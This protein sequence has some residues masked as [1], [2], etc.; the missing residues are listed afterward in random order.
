MENNS[1][2]DIR[3]CVNSE[4]GV[5]S[6]VVVNENMQMTY[7][8]N[9]EVTRFAGIAKTEYF[10]RPMVPEKDLDLLIKGFNNRTR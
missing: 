9:N 8:R 7:E 6:A 2:I 5:A 10:F 1:L 4:S 3:I